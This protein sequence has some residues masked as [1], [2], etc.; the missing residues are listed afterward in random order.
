M[1]CAN[2]GTS[3][4]NGSN[5]C[6]NCGTQVVIQPTS[7]VQPQVV[8]TV[9]TNQVPVQVN[10]NPVPVPA[11]QVQMVQ[12][13]VQ[14]V[15]QEVPQVPQV[16]QEVQQ[17][18]QVQQEVI[19]VP[20]VT[21]VPAQVQS[22][23][24]QASLVTEPVGMNQSPVSVTPVPQIAEQ[25]VVPPQ[26]EPVSKE[27]VIPPQVETPVQT[28]VTHDQNVIGQAIINPNDSVSTSTA[29]I[30][31]NQQPVSTSTVVEEKEV[32]SVTN[33]Q[34]EEQDIKN[35]LEFKEKKR[36][37]ARVKLLVFLIFVLL[38][39]TVAGLYFT[40]YLTIKTNVTIGKG[41]TNNLSTSSVS[42]T[43]TSKTTTTTVTTTKAIEDISSKL[44]ISGYTFKINDLYSL[45]KDSKNLDIILKN[46]NSMFMQIVGIYNGS[47]DE[48]SESASM[49][50]NTCQSLY[51]TCSY[52]G[53]TF[54]NYK[55]LYYEY[56]YNY[57]N[58]VHVYI[59]LESGIIVNVIS[60]NKNLNSTDVVN[61]IIDLLNNNSKENS[62]VINLENV[63]V[64]FSNQTD[65][66]LE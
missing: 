33:E 23:E 56:I 19:P 6:P 32:V 34:I 43:V 58:T 40:G 10:T 55:V 9:V 2:C 46:D 38:C 12:P 27:Q 24:P 36:K 60:R 28:I 44:L 3:I 52:Q 1:N 29:P 48:L 39:G 64:N 30:V 45:K 59:E 13:Q 62:E 47:L 66:S 18:P 7:L 37:K 53:T 65:Y 5:V 50:I 25:Q 22:V 41:T 61:N 21:E 54:G 49:D 57:L 17:V 20:Q 63:S 26:V 11:P 16:Q 8:Q 42:T 51:G 31:T 14:Q 15:Q 4:P 35:E